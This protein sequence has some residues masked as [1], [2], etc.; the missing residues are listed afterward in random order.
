MEAEAIR[1][2][3]EAIAADFEIRA[4]KDDR[5][6]PAETIDVVQALRGAARAAR[7]KR[8]SGPGDRRGREG[9]LL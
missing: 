5:S 6:V 3:L 7:P 8:S 9:E 4:N 1:T 2:R